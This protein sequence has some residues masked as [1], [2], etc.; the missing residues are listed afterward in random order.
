MDTEIVKDR[1]KFDVKEVTHFIGYPLQELNTD[2]LIQI[3]SYHVK[4]RNFPYQF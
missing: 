2:T 4:Q 3:I 1:S